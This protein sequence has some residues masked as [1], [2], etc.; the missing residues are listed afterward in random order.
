MK[1]VLLL[2]LTLVSIKINAQMYG[3]D[4]PTRFPTSDLYDTSSMLLL[5]KLAK[6]RSSSSTYYSPQFNDNRE[7]RTETYR[8]SKKEKKRVDAATYYEL[9]FS[10]FNNNDWGRVI[11][12]TKKAQQLGYSN[13]HL[14][15]I[16]G[17]AYQILG[18]WK[19]AKRN[20]IKAKRRGYKAAEYAL[21]V[22]E[23][24]KRIEKK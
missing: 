13:G 5:M 10:A 6:E 8:I 2:L 1:K 17:W 22:M 18:N 14:F 11:Y 12:Y 24:R 16:R 3:Y 20:Y 19:A 9:A 4:E 7:E 21:E 23:L 15:Y